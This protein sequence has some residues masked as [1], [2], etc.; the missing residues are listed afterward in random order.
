[1]VA[2]IGL[3]YAYNEF[4]DGTAQ[5]PP[6]ICFLYDTSNDFAADNTNYVKVRPLV[7]ELYT[8]NKSFSLE[9]TVE[10]VLEAN[11]LFYTRNE[12]YI[13]SER[14]FL[15]TYTMEVCING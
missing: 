4:P 14:M 11:G 10:S 3:P 8:D 12:T 13:A 9:Q 5:S 7:I 2:S 15:V 1:M 6:F